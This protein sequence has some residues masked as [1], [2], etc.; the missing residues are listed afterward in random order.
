MHDARSG[1]EHQRTRQDVNAPDASSDRSRERSDALARRLHPARDRGLRRH[2]RGRCAA[3]A[4]APQP[5]TCGVVA[6]AAP[7]RPPKGGCSGE[8]FTAAELR[9]LLIDELGPLWYCD[10]DSYPVGRDELAGDA[11]AGRSCSPTPSSPAPS[12]DRLEFPPFD[13]RLTDDERLLRLPAL[14]GG[15]RHPAR[16][17]RQR[18]LP[19]RLP[20]RARR[21]RGREGTRTAGIVDDAR[22]DHD[23]AAGCLPASR[24]A[25]SASPAGT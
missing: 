13:V 24:S 18:P 11:G 3:P 5:S 8:A 10:R 6:T 21:R 25:R 15:D 2:G 23:R 22:R 16:G 19:L 4:P 7:S 1:T 20:G 17:H 12:A 9:L 14:E